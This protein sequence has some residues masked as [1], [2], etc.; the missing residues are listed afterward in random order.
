MIM[1]EIG[2]VH[3]RFQV[4]HNEHMRYIL[5]GKQRCKHLIIGITNYTCAFVDAE[6]SKIDTHR[7]AAASNPF[8][9][10]ERMEMVRNSML[11]NG[12][13]LEDFTI[14]PFPIE[15]P[16]QIFNFVPKKSTF[17]ITIYDAWGRN[18]F[19]RLKN[20]GVKTEL[21][22]ECKEEEKIMSGT[23][24]RGLI[25]EDKQWAQLVPAAVYKYITQN[26]LDK[27]IKDVK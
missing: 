19:E 4:L 11:E 17:Y 13:P 23:L 3:G 20:L 22:W 24:I 15:K 6:I 12:I 14:V 21:L 18:K 7:L 16:E 5:A 26:G 8:T 27:R 25:K 1:D 10:Y 2:I 9:Y